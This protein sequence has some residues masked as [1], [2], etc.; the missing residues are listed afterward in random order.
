MRVA[1]AY[2]HRQLPDSSMYV[3]AH[4]VMRA[5]RAAGIEIEEL[6]YDSPGIG[7]KHGGM[8]EP[9]LAKYLSHY[10]GHRE[11]LVHD[12][13]CMG[14]RPGVG[15]STIHLA[16]DNQSASRWI[17]RVVGKDALRV[18]L[19]RAARTVV[20][21]EYL[22]DQLAKTFG[23][24]SVETVRTIFP[25]F[26]PISD[27]RQPN[28][29]DALWIGTSHPR[30]RLPF[31]LEGM[32]GLPDLR[33]VVRW[34]PPPTNMQLKADLERT[35]ERL[36][37]LTSI[38]RFLPEAEL[39]RLYRSSTC[40]VST[41]TDEGFQVPLMEAYFRGTRVVAP[42][43]PGVPNVELLRGVEG[44]H[45]FRPGDVL[46]L[47]RAIREASEAGAFRVDPKLTRSLSLETIGLQFKA[48]YEELPARL[49]TTS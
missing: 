31:F 35:M 42:D 29:Y 3:Y 43:D 23:P 4:R 24:R 17:E 32:S 40:L 7:A 12:T 16:S 9:Y 19:R 18:A 36:P 45:I 22:R 47:R 49:R 10:P 46:D 33:A 48:V 13:S 21:S 6:P 5:V 34:K 8:V 39:D 11:R 28:A 20:V 44:F 41:S 27:E 15:V 37:R 30:K 26:D 14:T 38:P 25:P 2:T 1:I